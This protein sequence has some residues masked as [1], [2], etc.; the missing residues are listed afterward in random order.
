MGHLGSLRGCPW[1][2][3][4]HLGPSWWPWVPASAILEAWERGSLVVPSGVRVRIC[5]RGQGGRCDARERVL[6][7]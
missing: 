5:L 6:G 1:Q 4:R 3:W 7:E 2:S